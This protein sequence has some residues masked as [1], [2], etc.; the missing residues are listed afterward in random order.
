MSHKITLLDNGWRVHCCSMVSDT[1]A[2][3]VFSFYHRGAGFSP[4]SEQIML[5][6][7]HTI[8]H[9]PAEESSAPA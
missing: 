4:Y 1:T 8:A 7:W 2:L 5:E 6:A 3:R 9:T